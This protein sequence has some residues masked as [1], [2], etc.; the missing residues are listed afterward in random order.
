MRDAICIIDDSE[1]GALVN[2][3]ATTLFGVVGRL[4]AP[5][6]MDI[7]STLTLLTRP[8]L[9]VMHSEA[10]HLE[11]IL[12][13]YGAK[14]NERW[15][16]FR[17]L[18]AAIKLFARVHYCSSTSPRACRGTVSSRNTKISVPASSRLDGSLR[19]CC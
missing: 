4:G 14:R 7:E 1:F 8:L 3:R 6:L 15:R 13:G 18:I 11:E 12:D 5:D 10:S 2:S 16:P 17:A 19:G 9:A